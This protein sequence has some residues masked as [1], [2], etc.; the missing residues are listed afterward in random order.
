VPRPILAGLLATGLSVAAL[1]APAPAAAVPADDSTIFVNELHYDNDGTDAGEFVEVAG[2]A[3]TDLSAWRLVLYNGANGSPYDTRQLSGT[4][5]DQQGGYGTMA[6]DYPTNGIQNGAPD[7]IALVHDGAVVQFLSYEGTLSA[8]SGPANGLTSTDIDVAQGSS[9]PVGSS[10]ELRGTGTTYG[11]FGWA[12]SSGSNSAGVPNSGQTFGEGDGEPP[13]SENCGDPAARIHQIQ[14]SGERFDPDFGGTQ[15]VEA[16]VTSVMLG[17]ISV[18]EEAAHTDAD[19]ETSEGI[20]VY[21]GGQDA[22]PA[23]SVVR[24]TG[25]VVEFGSG[26]STKTELT[27]ASV[28][29][30]DEVAPPVEAT[31]V[32]FPLSSPDDLEHYESM[33]VE[34]SDDLVISEYFNYDRF[35]EVVVAK[36]PRGWDRL[37]TP[38]AVVEPGTPANQL[39]AE[40]AKRRITIDDVST[41][42]NP[43]SLPHPG[44]GE[45][46]N[47][48]N[49]FRGGDTITGIEGIVDHAFGLYRLQPTAYGDY[50]PLNQRPADAPD[51][52]GDLEVASFNVLNYFLTLDRAGNRCG[53]EHDQD[54]RGADDAEELERQRTKILAALAE[55]DADVVGLMEMENTTGVE[56]AADLAKGLN[57]LLGAGTYDYV[58]TGT[59]GGDAIRVGFLYKPGAVQPVGDFEVLDSTDDP[60]FVDTKSRPMLT[61]TFDETTDGG[62]VTVSVNHLKSKGSDC[63]ELGDPDTGDGQ[64]NCNLTR[65]RAAEAIVDFL[66]EDP[67]G[68]GDPDHL[69]IGDLNAYDH[70]DPITALENGGYADQVERFNGELAYG[71]VFDGQAGYLDHALANVP[72][73]S[74][75]TGVADWHINADE[76]DVLDYDTTFKPDPVDAIHAPDAY[77]SSDHDP[78]LVGLDLDAAAPETCYLDGS[79]SIASYA[80]G[81]RGNGTPLPPAFSDA[82]QSLGLSDPDEPYWDEPYWTGLGLGGELVMEFT[83]PVQN[84]GGDDPDLRLVDAADGAS[85]DGDSAVVLA[86]GDGETWS[87]LGQVDGTGEVDLGQLSAAR[88]VRVVDSTPDS[89]PRSVDGYDVDAAEVLSGCA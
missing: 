23:G 33:L 74:Q 9:T 55:L 25:S 38:T 75:V 63:D 5:P 51:V 60:R 30:C 80:P 59:I 76:P 11:E 50:E 36:P 14:G 45:P 48:D 39:A 43:A 64:G 13:P 2:P 37:Y 83:R 42:Q 81:L 88:Y 87:E 86:S 7:G 22:P 3:G 29:V 40:Y 12:V 62:R 67:T 73:Q 68:S 6:F 41:T 19:P 26:G 89:G 84:L 21:L 16:V 20:F 52:G 27:D 72:L 15:S 58:D 10:L 82:S 4:V 54:C 77:R 24:A 85:G 47:L 8:A 56:P 31:E 57:D 28:Q 69:V 66:A 70:E 46:F 17:G 1:A 79:Q 65:T 18:Q 34:L 32:T 44:N 35:G 78:V 61:Q 49:R 71:Y 53:P